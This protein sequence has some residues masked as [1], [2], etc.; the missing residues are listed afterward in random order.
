MS[1]QITGKILPYVEATNITTSSLLL[2]TD[3][4]RDLSIRN[5]ESL[6]SN[7][8]KVESEIKDIIDTL[9][10]YHRR[11]DS[12]I[13]NN[14]IFVSDQK[15]GIGY[16]YMKNFDLDSLQDIGTQILNSSDRRDFKGFNLPFFCTINIPYALSQIS[17]VDFI[18][19]TEQLNLLKSQLGVLGCTNVLFYIDIQYDLITTSQ[20]EMRTLSDIGLVNLWEEVVNLGVRLN[21][22]KIF[23]DKV[24]KI[25]GRS[26]LS[27]SIV[28]T[29]RME[30]IVGFTKVLTAEA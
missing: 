4:L 5:L 2:T 14:L 10:N 23:S 21:E 20:A 27:D 25:I 17:A 28:T 13:N 9:S 12:D 6:I 7:L 3:R 16:L 18:N 26:N 19:Y 1:E 11:N 30:A 29:E 8:P 24:K 15:R 22:I